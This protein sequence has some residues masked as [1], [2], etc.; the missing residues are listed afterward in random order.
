MDIKVRQIL[1]LTPDEII[2]AGG[3]ERYY[4]THEE[5]ELQNTN[6]RADIAVVRPHCKEYQNI[7]LYRSLIKH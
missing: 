5:G 4:K 3:L 6:T 2:L 7:E 1:P